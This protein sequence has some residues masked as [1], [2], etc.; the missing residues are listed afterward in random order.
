MGLIS[1]VSSRTYRPKMSKNIHTFCLSWL[2]QGT[3][4]GTTK[5]KFEKDE[6]EVGQQTFEESLDSDET[7]NSDIESKND[8]NSDDHDTEQNSKSRSETLKEDDP[9]LNSD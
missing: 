1:R 5:N 3:I 2:K 6:I 4:L 9:I 7:E 8:N